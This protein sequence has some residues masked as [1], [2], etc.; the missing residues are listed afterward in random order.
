MHTNKLRQREFNQ[1]A[2]LCRHLSKILKIPVLLDSL[3]KVKDTKLQTEVGRAGRLR[4]LKGAF[5]VSKEIGGKRLLL[6]DDV[7]TTGATATECSSVLK[8]AGAKEIDVVAL[9]RS[10]P[11]Y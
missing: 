6:V 8:K 10:M 11:R 3:I 7:I 5:A 9:A 1:T 2:L 4:N